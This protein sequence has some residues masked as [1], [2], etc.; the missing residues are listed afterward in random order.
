MHR[1]DFHLIGQSL[2]TKCHCWCNI[3]ELGVL[4]VWSHSRIAYAWFKRMYWNH[5]FSHIVIYKFLLFD[6]KTMSNI[7]IVN[8]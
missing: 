8:T 2:N 6:I 7:E 3:S 5:V 1:S 4:L